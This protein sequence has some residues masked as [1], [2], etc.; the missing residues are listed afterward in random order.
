MYR[1]IDIFNSTAAKESNKLTYLLTYLRCFRAYCSV[2]PRY[3]AARLVIIII[4]IIVRPTAAIAARKIRESAY[5]RKPNN[6]LKIAVVYFHRHSPYASVGYASYAILTRHLSNITVISRM[7]CIVLKIQNS[8]IL[9]RI[10]RKNVIDSSPNSAAYNRT[11]FREN[12]L[13][14]SRPFTDKQTLQQTQSMTL[15]PRQE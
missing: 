1:Y 3:T 6:H 13:R 12:C 10:N 2:S 14:I 8:A 5:L 7:Q 9:S 15:P 11:R 4:I